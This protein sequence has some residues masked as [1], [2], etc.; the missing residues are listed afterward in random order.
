MMSFHHRVLNTTMS[1]G[2][3][4]ADLAS[5]HFHVPAFRYERP[6]ASTARVHVHPGLPVSPRVLALPM[7]AATVSSALTHP[8]SGDAEGSD[9]LGRALP[10]DSR[11]YGHGAVAAVA[12]LRDEA[13]SQPL[14]TP[15]ELEH[16]HR[17]DVGRRERALEAWRRGHRPNLSA[18]RFGPSAE[19]M[20]GGSSARG[21]SPP[22]PRLTRPRSPHF[23]PVRQRRRA[24]G[25]VPAAGSGSSASS[26]ATEVWLT[27][28]A[29]VELQAQAETLAREAARTLGLP[30]SEHGDEAT[31][32]MRRSDK[33]SAHAPPHLSDSITDGDALLAVDDDLHAELEASGD[34]RA[35]QPESSAV[36]HESL[37]ATMRAA[38]EREAELNSL[39]RQLGEHALDNAREA[40]RREQQEHQASATTSASTKPRIPGAP[41]MLSGLAL[42]G[43]ASA[44][45]LTASAAL[46]DELDLADAYELS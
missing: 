28:Q 1:R 27:Q 12:R 19:E 35:P 32:V 5:F 41:V 21:G 11:A 26:V 13:R 37:L 25:E 42:D 23:T 16:A 31:F 46:G 45:A 8:H 36:S 2:A 43:M 30:Q 17:M 3:V 24:P 40:L 15:G 9:D 4:A 38:S 18:C 34:A 14:F 44:G 39:S 7:T 29:Q 10:T 33:G 20:A 6:G 22:K